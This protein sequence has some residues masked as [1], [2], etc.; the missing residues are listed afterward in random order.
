M[1]NRVLSLGDYIQRI[2]TFDISNSKSHFL[3]RGQDVKGNLLPSIARKAP[4]EN[5]V[6]AE[7]E[8]LDSVRLM[9]ASFLKESEHT[10]LDHLVLAQ[11][12]KMKTR[13][14][15][16]ST[17]PLVALWFA[18]VSP[19]KGDVY[20]YVLDAT[21]FLNKGIYDKDPFDLKKTCVFQPR[22]NNNRIVAQHGWFTIHRYSAK[23]QRFVPLEAN[24][25][26]KENITELVIAEKS[27]PDLLHS[28]DKYGINNRTLFP[29]LEGL[30]EYQNWKFNV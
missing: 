28:L 8:M 1:N 12:H 21:N 2:D 20:V 4:T 10:D 19:K 22:L 25:D 29:D 16:W 5:S 9:G 30:C 3:F 17:N 26:I 27:R 23:N 15:D 7:K 13:L 6:N 18:C 11:H 24:K 14:L